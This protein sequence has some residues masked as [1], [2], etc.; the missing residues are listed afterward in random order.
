[1]NVGKQVNKGSLFIQKMAVA[2]QC[3]VRDLLEPVIRDSLG[4]TPCT[5]NY[6]LLITLSLLSRLLFQL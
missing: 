1:M 5:P 6:K 4:Q 2:K 3:L